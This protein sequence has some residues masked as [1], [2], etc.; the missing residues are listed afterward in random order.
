MKPLLGANNQIVSSCTVL[1]R[2]P[3]ATGTNDE[4]E[5]E[6]EQFDFDSGD[7]IPEADRQAL[8]PPPPGPGN[9]TEHQEAHAVG[10]SAWCAVSPLG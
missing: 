1:E 3:K 7:E 4:E 9:S 8:V 2:E 10:K 5:D 6:G